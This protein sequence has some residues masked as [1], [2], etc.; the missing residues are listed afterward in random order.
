MIDTIKKKVKD[1]LES[2]EIAGF[3]GLAL[4]HGHVAPHLYRKGDDMENMVLGDTKKAGDSRYPL[5]KYLIN[6]YRAYPGEVFG[7]LVRGCDDR[8]LQTLYTWNQLDPKKVV[9]VGIACPQE[10]ADACECSQPYPK[11]IMAGEAVQ[12]GASK[13]VAEIDALGLTERFSYW[14]EEFVKCIKCYGCSNICPMCFCSECSLKCDDLIKK[15]ELPPEIPAFHH[16][17]AMHMV[18]R[19]IDCGLCEEACPS[20]IP[21]RTLYK[22]VNAVMDEQFDFK[23]GMNR[24]RS[25]LNTIEPVQGKE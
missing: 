17:R 21:L 7:V 5:N 19:C 3:M 16:T 20:H 6:L 8:G 15:G 18:G 23:T 25:P 10:L 14:M 1:L 12:A 4:K 11:E 9:P 13:S 22:K 24:R 2:D